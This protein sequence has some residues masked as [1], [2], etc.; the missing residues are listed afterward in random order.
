MTNTDIIFDKIKNIDL[1]LEGMNYNLLF[2][3]RCYIP[4]QDRITRWNNLENATDL[5]ILNTIVVKCSTNNPEYSLVE[6]IINIDKME[7][8]VYYDMVTCCEEL[9]PN[10]VEAQFEPNGEWVLSRGSI[11][12]ITGEK[13]TFFRM[14]ENEISKLNPGCLKSLQRGLQSGPITK[15]YSG[16]GGGD[17]K[18]P[19]YLPLHTGF[20]LRMPTTDIDNWTIKD[21]KGFVVS[22]SVG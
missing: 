10:L 18:S 6:T 20:S 13:N 9:I 14:Y 21:N 4:E 5:T 17:P 8:I 2:P 12:N 11:L 1:R 19:I 7:H 15:V 22:E 16:G 3:I